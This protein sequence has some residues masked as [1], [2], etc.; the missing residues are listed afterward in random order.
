[1]TNL[2]IEKLYA[3]TVIKVDR[4]LE[5]E[6]KIRIKKYLSSSVSVL[7]REGIVT[8]EEARRE[9]LKLGVSL[10]DVSYYSSS[11][12]GYSTPGSSCPPEEPRNN[13]C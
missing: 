4:E 13:R 5:T 6:A 10:D 7:V 11:D 2:I 9:E 1:V 3:Q 8:K 12:Y